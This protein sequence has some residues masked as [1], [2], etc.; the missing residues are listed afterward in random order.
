M[1]IVFL[2]SGAFGLPTLKALSERHD[3]KA[4]VTQP[5]RPAGRGKTLTP[6]PIGD[7][8]ATAMAGVPLLKPADVN[9]DEVSSAI[10][11]I[12]ADA[13]VVIAFGQ[14]L[15]APLLEGVFAINLHAS[16]LPRWRGA[17]PINWAI[18]DGD[19]V[20]GNSVITLA[21]R[22]DAGLVLGQSEGRRIESQTAGDLHD[23]LAL[24]GPGVVEEV[25]SAHASGQ[26]RGQA[27]DESLVT[28]APKLGAK[29]R[30]VDLAQ[31]AEACVRRINGLSPWP[32]VTLRVGDVE[33]K[34]LRAEPGEGG[35]QS[36]AG[37]LVDPEAGLVSCG[38]GLIRLLE[39]QPAGKRPMSWGDLV[40]GRRLSAG[41][42]V[43]GG[44]G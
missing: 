21:E 28:L 29:D 4:I 23:V 32:G 42:E 20:T 38:D 30:W 14:K 35:G 9:E 24:D 37:R 22:M 34:A 25:L 36:E 17:A 18:I 7:H 3:V 40:R 1:E 44:R 13:W 2:G 12:D 26:V 43:D 31:P 10:R 8:A 39:V 19:E 41:I 11:R 15:S 6:T 27:Q 33:L 16:L 5:D